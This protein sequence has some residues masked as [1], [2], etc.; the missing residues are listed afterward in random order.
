MRRTDPDAEVVL[1]R[2]GVELTS[3]PLR[4]SGAPGFP[5]VDEVARLQVAARRLGCAIVVRA[6]GAPL[7]ELLDLAGLGEVVEGG[8]GSVRDR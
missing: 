8:A 7:R 4:G 2:G 6:A 5:V 1:L 3:W